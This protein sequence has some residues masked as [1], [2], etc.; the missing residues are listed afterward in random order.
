MKILKSI[1]A[2][3]LGFLTVVILSIGTDAILHKF[4]IF[5]DGAVFSYSLLLLALFYRTVYTVLGGYVTATLAP[6]RPMKHAI[7][8]GFVGL[9]AGTAGAIANADLGPAWYSWGLVVLALPSVWLGARLKGN[10]A[11]SEASY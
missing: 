8:L 5:P 9:V 11:A 7:I 4:N 2:I 3:F 6:E 1:G 10:K